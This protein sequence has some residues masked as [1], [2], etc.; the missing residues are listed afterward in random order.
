[1][2]YVSKQDIYS[3]RKGTL[4]MFISTILFICKKTTNFPETIQTNR[5]PF[6]CYKNGLLKK[7]IPASQFRL[8]TCH[9]NGNTFKGQHSFRDVK[10][11]KLWHKIIKKYIIHVKH[12]FFEIYYVTQNA[13]KTNIFS[14]KNYFVEILTI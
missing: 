11:E 1:M 6:I 2:F 3:S 7:I 4:K 8:C 14:D 13:P 5:R 10:F 9:K 12:F